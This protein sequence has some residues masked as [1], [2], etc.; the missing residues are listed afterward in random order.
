MNEWDLVKRFGIAGGAGDAWD[1]RR[2][3]VDASMR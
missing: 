3:A 2:S 1:P